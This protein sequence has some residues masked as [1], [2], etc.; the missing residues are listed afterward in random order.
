MNR[1][2]SPG[3]IVNECVR[4]ARE[5]WED[6]WNKLDL[7]Q[8][9]LLIAVAQQDVV[10]ASDHEKEALLDT[11]LVYQDWHKDLHLFSEEFARFILD[12]SPIR[13]S[14]FRPGQWLE[15]RYEIRAL[16]WATPHSQIAKA[17]DRRWE[18]DV[19]IKFV[20]MS[21]DSNSGYVKVLEERLKREAKLLAR[22][23]HSNIGMVYDILLEPIGIV[24]EWVDGI[25]LAELLREGH[26]IFRQQAIELG[27]QIA[28]ALAYVHSK[29][30][31]HR[32]IKP[33]NI[34]ETSSGQ[35]K[36]IDFDIAHGAEVATISVDEEG[37]GR[38]VGTPE[39]S[40]PEQ[41]R[42]D[43]HTSPADMFSLGV[44]LYRLLTHE[45]PFKYGNNPDSYPDRNLPQPSQGNIPDDLYWILLRLLDERPSQRLDAANLQKELRSISVTASTL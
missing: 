25:S 38:Y 10:T 9:K 29:G 7:R 28:D 11:S 27:L 26:S 15:D 35:Y 4:E 6:Y 1:E 17:W 19:A 44:V 22:L 42:R 12:M 14:P 8:Q 39:Y 3:Q 16:P 13:L 5:L 34:I 30:L 18:R 41:L 36:L 40:A 32:D 45:L 43:V 20:Q 24:M 31:V 33:S 2:S 37:Y 23:Q 21:A